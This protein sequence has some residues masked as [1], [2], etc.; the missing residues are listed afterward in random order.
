M[1][2]ILVTGIGGNVGQGILRNLQS[3]SH[4]FHLI[5]TNVK[6]VSAGNHLCNKVYVT[7]YAYE[8]NFI[9]TIQQICATEKVDL[10]I[11]STD[12]EAY[13]LGLHQDKI[14][15]IVASSPAE[16]TQICLDKY[17]TWQKFSATNIPFAESFLP[18]QYQ[19]NIF[20]EIVVKPREGR[21]SRHIYFNPLHSKQFDDTYMVQ[22]RYFG[23]EITTVFYITQENKLHGSIT[24]DRELENGATT[25][26]EVNPNYDELVTPILEQIKNNFVIRGSCNLQS[27]VT[28]DGIVMPFEVNCRISGTNSI[29]SQFG[30]KDVE[31][32]VD[33]FLFKKNPQAVHIQQGA[34]VRILMDVIY[35][36]ISLHEIENNSTKHYIF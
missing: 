26:C 15:A 36:N 30:F 2:T 33:E 5:G 12:Y 6:Q 10:I 13:Y 8:A 16:T 32:T 9:A 19:E 34:A 25:Y 24:F 17:V 29:R 14:A 28:D 35:P 21:G 31:Y 18:S 4:S 3:L 20:A 27:I 7:P 11:P 22:K 23:K 1:H